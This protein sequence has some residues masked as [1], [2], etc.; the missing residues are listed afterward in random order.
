M[1]FDILY[2][3]ITQIEKQLESINE[4]KF[5]NIARLYLSYRYNNVLSTGFAL[6][7]EKSKAGVPD[8][9]IPLKEGY[10]T[11]NEITTV[12]PEKLK[13]KLKKDIADCFEQKK[14][15]ET[16]I[17]Q[18]ILIC[19]RKISPELYNELIEHKQKYSN[20]K[21]EVIGIDD[22]ANHIFRDYPSLCIELGIPIDTGQ[23]LE[24]EGFI[25][26]YEKSK[27]ATTLQN[28][29]YNRDEELKQAI[30]FLNN[31]N[32]ILINGQ[33]GVG[34]TKLSLE[35]A[36]KFLDDN[37]EYK[38]KYIINNAGAPI[39]ED[40]KAQLVIDQN[41]LV[42][43]DD[44]NKLKSNLEFIANFLKE[45][46]RGNIKLILTVRD[47][48]KNEV[49]KKLEDFTYKEIG[50]TNFN[51][52]ELAKILT[53][54]EFNISSYGID[55][56]YAISKG[57]P[58]LAIMAAS[59]ALNKD[60]DRL[61]N[62]TVIFEEYFSSV[63]NDL[64]SLQDEDLLKVAGL[65]SIFRIIDIGVK[66]VVNEI[67]SSFGISE[68][69]LT[70]KLRLLLQYEV[71]DEFKGAYKVAD[72][73]LGEYIFYLVFI[74]KQYIPF[75]TLL[76]LHIENKGIS[77]FKILTPIIQNYG[78][79]KIQEKISPI[80]K[81]VWGE[82]KNHSSYCLKFLN[83]FWFYLPSES[84][85]YIKTEIENLEQVNLEDLKFEVYRDNHIEQYDDNII[86][87]LVK[88]RQLNDSFKLAL[89]LLVK[90]GLNSQLNFSKL[91]KAF[92]QSF[93]Y[94]GYSYEEKYYTQ[95]ILLDFLYKKAQENTFFYSKLILFIADKFLIDSYHS[96]SSNGITSTTK[97]LQVV[98]INEQKEFRKKLWEF[99]FNCFADDKLKEY[100]YSFFE[101]HRYSSGLS[102]IKEVIEYD[103]DLI[104]P[105]FQG[106]FS[107]KSFRECEIVYEYINQLD[108]AKIEYDES[109][110]THFS[111][112]EFEL[113]ITLNDRALYK[114]DLLT[115][116]AKGFKKQDYLELLEL[117]N[118][119]YHHKIDY[120]APNNFSFIKDSIT[121]ILINL[122]NTDF[123]LFLIVFKKVYEYEYATKL[124]TGKLFK[125]IN[126]DKTKAIKLKALMNG[127]EKIQGN[128]ITLM[129][130]L[131][132]KFITI[133]DYRIFKS[134]ILKER[135]NNY[136]FLDEVYEKVSYLA[137]DLK[138]ELEEII[139]RIHYKIQSDEYT[140][141]HNDFF[142]FLAKEH[143]H[144]FKSKI[145]EIQNIYLFMNNRN[146]RYDYGA[147]FLHSI[148]TLV[149]NFIIKL[150]KVREYG[151]YDDRNNYLLNNVWSL[152]N[153]EAVVTC[154][155]NFF[156]EIPIV[157]CNDTHVASILFNGSS[158][159]EKT[160]IKSIIQKSSNERELRMMFNIAVSKY[161]NERF[162]FLEL[163]LQ[164]KTDLDFFR[165]LD[166]Y[167]QSTTFSGSR[168]P[169]IQFEINQY[170]ELKRFFGSLSSL[171]LLPHMDWVDNKIKYCKLEIEEERKR[172][173]LDEWGI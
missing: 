122:A 102:K 61:N 172:E 16:K 90:Y 136:W 76:K 160:L 67:Q 73:I 141:V 167:V 13:T 20:A 173:F 83:D 96:T 46:R 91:L 139:D 108:F 41:Y 127:H 34:K 147:K 81:D 124:L 58:R 145:K 53:S 54:K 121:K 47:Y 40:L 166:F 99:I 15:P 98:T 165:R 3:M 119:I 21:L 75:F 2:I 107:N 11:F 162:Q 137:I 149:P 101:K 5:A 128:I 60:Y 134:L 97:H 85:L 111:N 86:D 95:R 142:E 79:E 63:K 64:E 7:Q 93:S 100:T 80:I 51:R 152:E 62:A 109:L 168:I 158:E 123:E 153:A 70:S 146:N 159:R 38:I 1:V 132:Q 28:T 144:T 50:L 103:K 92:R 157:F 116:F 110:K 35:I 66:E 87:L 105:F 163:L 120:F 135:V 138:N 161:H 118:G 49:S 88:F 56:I 140:Y 71:A 74:D 169:R 30:E 65:L 32:L 84:L 115:D 22:F 17:A 6:G 69:T 37:L 52:E 170:D 24:V 117:I 131:P 89:Q 171:D 94:S 143:Y 44:A 23:I 42:V 18:I 57:N 25:K 82:V 9:F 27:F 129:R 26:Q 12:L 19:N 36:K 155:L 48:V 78:F 151:M 72:Q 8:N 112:E 33:A 29:F 113:F 31:S 68:E 55:K 164:K 126:Y 125:E 148:L 43:V 150:L 45:D 130:C 14:I 4:D 133:E 39:W 106:N 156:K 10:Y 59:A 154:A 104:V 77:L 114:E